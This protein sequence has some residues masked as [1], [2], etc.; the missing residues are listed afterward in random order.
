M[1][2]DASPPRA[3]RSL[4]LPADDAS[5]AR[6]TRAMEDYLKAAYRLQEEGGLATTQRLAEELGVSGPSVTNMVK[7]L[8]EQGLLRHARPGSVPRRARSPAAPPWSSWHCWAC[9]WCPSSAA[10][11]RRGTPS[12]SRRPR[13]P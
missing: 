1:M 13:P 12:S 7:R 4:G 6:P 3:A 11:G 5:A 10:T 8:H 9:T 2:T